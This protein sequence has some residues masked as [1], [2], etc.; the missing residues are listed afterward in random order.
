MGRRRETAVGFES[1][2]G[3]SMRTCRTL[4]MDNRGLG[5]VGRCLKVKKTPQPWTGRRREAAVGFR[6]GMVDQPVA[7]ERWW[8]T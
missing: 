2:F 3:W 1:S 8:W 4:V 6:S 7:V 5:R